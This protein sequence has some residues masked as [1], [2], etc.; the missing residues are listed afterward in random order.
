M[1]DAGQHPALSRRVPELDG[2]RGWAAF[3]VLATHVLWEIFGNIVPAFRN[4]ITACLLNG[5]FDVAVFFVLSG[6]VLSASFLANGRTLTVVRLLVKRYLRLT[7]PIIFSCLMSVAVLVSGAAF[8]HLAAPIVGSPDWLGR[9]LS[10]DISVRSFIGYVLLGVYGGDQWDKPYNEFLW[11]MRPEL[12]GSLCIFM[13]LFMKAHLRYFEGVLIAAALLF[14]AANSFLGCFP[15][16]VL[17]AS[18]RGRGVF[19]RLQRHRFAPL[20]SGFGLLI[21]LAATGYMQ[22]HMHWGPRPSSVLG[23]A[24]LLFVSCNRP[25]CRFFGETGVSRLLGHI[26][27]PLYLVHFAILV[28]FTSWATVTAYD[29]GALSQW[30]A[31]GISL[32]S[33]ILSVAAAFAFLP[34]EQ[35]TQYVNERW[36]RS[37]LR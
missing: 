16:G 22:V 7:I 5:E 21:T 20:V 4:P 37:I 28:S 2:I 32:A 6:E 34:V 1:P 11:T 13:L 29:A 10:F 24:F 36:A 9:F 23:C 17:F 30:V 15:I 18:L 26:S 31:V 33:I 35:L 19:A 8:N 3:S 12:I 25:A 14:L 27:F